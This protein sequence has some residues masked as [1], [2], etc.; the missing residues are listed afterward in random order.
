MHKNELLRALK[1]AI[2]A[3]PHTDVNDLTNIKVEKMT[4]HDHITRLDK[5]TRR[6]R[7]MA[8]RMTPVL[9]AAAVLLLGFQWY[10]QYLLPVANVTLETNP[11]FSMTLNRQLEI[12][13]IRPLNDDATKVLGGASFKG[14]SFEHTMRTLLDDLAP[15]NPSA[16][17][18]KAYLFSTATRN[19]RIKERIQAIEHDVAQ[20]FISRHTNTVVAFQPLSFTDGKKLSK[21]DISGRDMLTATLRQR[22]PAL[23]DEALHE[24]SMLEL[25][26]MSNRLGVGIDIYGDLTPPAADATDDD[27][28][29]TEPEATPSAP[30]PAPI[31][32]Q[33]PAPAPAPVPTVPQ[34]APPVVY[35][36]DDLYDDLYDDDDYGGDDYGY[37]DDGDDT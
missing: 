19:E 16:L 22:E 4:Q 11:A 7:P 8:V 15:E 18:P 30:P 32:A 13:D 3:L 2:N 23:H 5:S 34:P 1:R 33:I 27:D 14:A 36:D 31:P 12:L 35:D 6:Q 21:G 28:T 37:D 17:E 10:T 24:R 29:G 25:L 26:R 9:A 20:S